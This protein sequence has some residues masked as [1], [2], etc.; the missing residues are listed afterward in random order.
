MFLDCVGMKL[1]HSE[2]SHT[3]ELNTER[4]D[5]ILTWEAVAMG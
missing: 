3:R 5:G 1:E 4:S 2:E